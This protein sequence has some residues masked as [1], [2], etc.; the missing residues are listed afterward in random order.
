M[1]LLAESSVPLGDGPID[2]NPID[3]TGMDGG[4]RASMPGFRARRNVSLGA[5]GSRWVLLGMGDWVFCAAW[6]SSLE[7]WDR[8]SMPCVLGSEASDRFH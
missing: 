2:F 4:Y 6:D 7:S 8:A 3:S 1:P 5:L